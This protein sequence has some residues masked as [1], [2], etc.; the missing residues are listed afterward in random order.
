MDNCR[1][2]V[3]RLAPVDVAVALQCRE[4]NRGSQHVD[5]LIYITEHCNLFCRYCEPAGARAMHG[6]DLG[7]DIDDLVGFLARDPDARLQFYGGEPLLR[8]DLVAAILARA[9]Y[10]FAMLQTNGQLLERLDDASLARLDAIAVSLDG[11]PEI[12]DRFR[13][14]G[15]HA[16][17][18]AQI[19]ALRAR[20]YRGRIDARMTISPG[21]DFEAALTYLLDHSPVRFDRVYWQLNALFDEA[22]WR[23]HAEAIREWFEQVYNPAVRRQV[24]RWARRWVVQGRQDPVVPFAA[25]MHDLLSGEQV[26]HVR[27]GSG[28][29]MWA[30]G[31]EGGLY[32]C[33]LLR[34]EQDYRVGDLDSSPA[35]L[36]RVPL[37]ER[38]Q[39]CDLL[40]ICGGR[41]LFASLEPE[42]NAEGFDL[43][44]DS[45]RALV[46]AL[47][48]QQPLFEAL[49]GEG[50][51]DLADLDIGQDYEIIP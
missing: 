2:A 23:R 45:V 38:C 43:V 6:R 22:D 15:V 7:Y 1:A 50:L 5:Y 36:P 12:T 11:G 34:E 25:L 24:A 29:R 41:C 49:V 9:P 27:C 40:G 47:R 32:P 26:D 46:E 42:W 21:V 3:Q 14:H 20:G 18:L 35:G 33:P 28:H 13:G 37:G 16:T 44:C 31:P 30:V 51:L 19:E 8:V 4:F 48:E 17:A 10:R 39:R